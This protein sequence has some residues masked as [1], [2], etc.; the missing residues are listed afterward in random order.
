MFTRT[1]IRNLCFYWPELFLEKPIFVPNNTSQ[2]S[3][4][5]RNRHRAWI[6]DLKFVASTYLKCAGMMAKLKLI[7]DRYNLKLDFSPTGN[8]PV[9]DG[10]YTG[11]TH[12]L[13]EQAVKFPIAKQAKLLKMI[14]GLLS[15]KFFPDGTAAV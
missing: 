6:D 14:D 11:W 5:P 4:D 7:A 10:T 9:Q 1:L 2:E 12:S 8:K 3:V 13:T 15:G